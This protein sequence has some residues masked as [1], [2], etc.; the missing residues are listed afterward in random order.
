MESHVGIPVHGASF[1]HCL[2]LCL[3]LCDY[4]KK[5]LKKKLKILLPY[6]SKIAKLGIYPE[7]T[8]VV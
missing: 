7:D 8:K 2:C 6:D 3:S 4:H 1:S 5:I